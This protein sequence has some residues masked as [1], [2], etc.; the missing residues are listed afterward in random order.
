MH[1]Y[2]IN[3][4]WGRDLRATFTVSFA[5]IVLDVGHTES[6]KNDPA[7]TCRE[8]PQPPRTGSLVVNF[9]YLE[10]GGG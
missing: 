8:F 5:R 3:E 7:S 4:I 1:S 9:L 10:R 2:R 6:G